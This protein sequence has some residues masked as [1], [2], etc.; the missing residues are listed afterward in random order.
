M[1]LAKEISHQ[2]IEPAIDTLHIEN[3]NKKSARHNLIFDL[4]S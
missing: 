2:L 3:Y 1:S 4:P